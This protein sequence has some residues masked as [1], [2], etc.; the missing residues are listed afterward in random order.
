VTRNAAIL[1]AVVA[2]AAAGTWYWNSRRLERIRAPLAVPF[3]PGFDTADVQGWLETFP[4][5]TSVPLAEY[6]PRWRPIFGR[7]LVDGRLEAA[8]GDPEGG[9]LRDRG[10]DY[11]FRSDGPRGSVEITAA[12]WW[13]GTG[14]IGVQGAVQ[15][16]P[17]HQ[18]YE[19]VLW[20]GRLAL[21]YFIGPGPDQ[22]ELLARSTQPPVGRGHY[23]IVYRLERSD[24]SWRMQ[25]LLQ[26]ATG[27]GEGEVLASAGATDDRLGEGAQGIGILSGGASSYI[28]G[29]AVR[30]L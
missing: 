11:A 13:D 27:Q 20:E 22:Y 5:R 15:P 7:L 17:P 1:L 30:R 26:D 10:N 23:R 29:V 24:G 6:D 14:G 18:F 4:A 16:E 3:D 2:A 19:A 9:W 21:I 28:S 25:A 12:I 8:A